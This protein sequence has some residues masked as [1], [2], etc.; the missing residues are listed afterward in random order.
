MHNTICI[1]YPFS[2][3]PSLAVRQ[4]RYVPR[5]A[6]IHKKKSAHEKCV[7]PFVTELRLLQPAGLADL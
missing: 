3:P 2:H 7:A 1:S 6:S 5:L 4:G